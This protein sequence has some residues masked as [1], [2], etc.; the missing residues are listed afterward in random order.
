LHIDRRIVQGEA[1]L[2]GRLIQAT[3]GHG[4][5]NTAFI[6]RL[7]AT[8]R[9]RLSALVRRTRTLARRP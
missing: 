9:Q 3:Q 1:R 7:K 8:F 2:I 4:G 5:I 6:E